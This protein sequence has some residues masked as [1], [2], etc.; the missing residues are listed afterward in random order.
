ML[1]VATGRG[2]LLMLGYQKSVSTPAGYHAG[3]WTLEARLKTD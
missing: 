1:R 2:G 3:Q